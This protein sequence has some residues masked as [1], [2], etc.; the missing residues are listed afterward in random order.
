VKPRLLSLLIIPLLLVGLYYPSTGWTE[1]ASAQNISPA[2]PFSPSA[3]GSLAAQAP[4]KKAAFILTL[5]DQL[6]NPAPG[7]LSPL[8]SLAASGQTKQA[9]QQAVIES[10]Q[11][12]GRD[13]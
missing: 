10:L 11:S 8:Q 4:D 7:G 13:R 9:R 12:P 1:R 5:S 6:A 3:R 2:D